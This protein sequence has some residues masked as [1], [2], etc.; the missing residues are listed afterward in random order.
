MKFIC[1]LEIHR[2]TPWIT[3]NEAKVGA[4]VVITQKRECLYCNLIETRIA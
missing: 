1:F 3:I 2:F 4:R